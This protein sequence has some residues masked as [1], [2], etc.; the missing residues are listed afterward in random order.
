M[1]ARHRALAAL[2][3]VSCSAMAQAPAPTLMY[4]GES[5]PTRFTLCQREVHGMKGDHKQLLRRCL[6]RRL[7]G[8]RLVERNCRRQTGGVSGVAARQLAQRDCVQTAL[9]VPSD[10]LPK[11]PPPP[12]PA[13]VQAADAGSAVSSA[14][15]APPR[16][17]AAGEN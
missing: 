4:P 12:P 13:P 8:E 1:L 15:A 17:P 11:R 16:A 10:K 5:F 6:N 14:A 9:A 2:L 3:W 7:E